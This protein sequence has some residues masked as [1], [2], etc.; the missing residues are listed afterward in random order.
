MSVLIVSNVV[1]GAVVAGYRRIGILKS[2]G[3]TPAQVVAAYVG[4]VVF[5]AVIGCLAGVGIGNLLS[6]PLLSK[7]ANVY[8]VGVLTVPTWVSVLVPAAVCV[9][10]GIAALLP[11]LRAGRLSALPAAAAA[12]QRT[13]CWAGS[14]C[15]A[16]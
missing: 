1:S 12:T 8:G 5:S 10:V 3:F 9:L 15:P 11:A 6:V 16:R 4:Q 7:T 2:I 13:G 14:G